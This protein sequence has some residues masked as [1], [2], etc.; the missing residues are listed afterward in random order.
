M[1][2]ETL[3]AVLALAACGGSAGPGGGSP[4]LTVGGSYQISPTVLSNPCGSVQVLPGPA[5]VTQSA[6]A[7]DFRLTHAGQTY[8][9]RVESGGSF[10]TEPLLITF[11]PGSTD[12]V[13]ISGRFTTA[14]FDATVA[15][16]TAHA[17]AA[18]CRYT[19][20]WAASKQGA[21]NVIP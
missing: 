14:G 18:P 1:R 15:V 16:D 19:V 2:L 9:G 5:T 7:P 21:P 11:A 8:T 17:G 3:F 20:A 10:T 4:V 12:T 13:T 6:G